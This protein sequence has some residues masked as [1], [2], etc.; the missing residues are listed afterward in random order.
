VNVALHLFGEVEVD[1]DANVID[2]QPA[3]RN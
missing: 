1:H 3:G 2:I